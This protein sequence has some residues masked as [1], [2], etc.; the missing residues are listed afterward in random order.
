MMELAMKTITAERTIGSHRVESG[1]MQ[2]LLGK[3][4]R[5]AGRL[6]CR[7]QEVK[8]CAI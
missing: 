6:S 3:G 8:G 1:V 2:I 7:V 4:T 5:D